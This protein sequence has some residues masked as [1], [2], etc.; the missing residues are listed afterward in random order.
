MNDAA[1]ADSSTASGTA[2]PQETV[3]PRVFALAVEPS[4][5]TPSA[6]LPEANSALPQVTTSR[7]QGVQSVFQQYYWEGYVGYT[8]VHFNEV[9]GFSNNLNGAN[10]AADFFPH[11]GH[12]GIE[13]EGFGTFGSLSHH[14]AELWAGM[15]GARYRFQ[16]PRGLQI[17]GHGLVG[18]AKFVPQTALGSE[19][20]LAYEVG[21]GVDIG[22]FNQ[23]IAYRFA[24]D[25][26]GTHIFGMNQI[27]PK[28]SA[29]IVFKY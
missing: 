14:T 16:A 12:L 4:N 11:Y 21:G 25:M 26:L 27:S 3:A 10:V 7:D 19:T 22:G 20:G 9:S 2:T 13:G 5:S 1:A 18:G 28:F 8:F 29:G 23:R 15:G 17:W 6:A 24:V